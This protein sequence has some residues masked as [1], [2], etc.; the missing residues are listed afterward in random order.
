MNLRKIIPLKHVKDA[1]FNLDSNDF[2][3]TAKF[4]S[5]DSYNLAKIA[6]LLN[7]NVDVQMTINWPSSKPTLFQ[8]TANNALDELQCQYTVGRIYRNSNQMK[9]ILSSKQLNSDHR[10]QLEAELS[11]LIIDNAQLGIE[12]QKL[13]GT[14]NTQAQANLELAFVEYKNKKP[15]IFTDAEIKAQADLIRTKRK[16]AIDHEVAAIER[17]QKLIFNGFVLNT[18]TLDKLKDRNVINLTKLDDPKKQ[19]LIQATED[20]NQND[21]ALINSDQPSLNSINSNPEIEIIEK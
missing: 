14:H 15:K 10:A 11:N 13:V 1:E 21:L 9:S 18:K 2:S 5:Y 19:L 12:F 8:Q 16:A 7:Q 6:E 20:T 17:N 3:V 4:S